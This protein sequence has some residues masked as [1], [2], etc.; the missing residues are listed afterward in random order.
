MPPNPSFRSSPTPTAPHQP[1]RLFI[2]IYCEEVAFEDQ[3][4]DYRCPQ[5]NA[6]KRR[7]SKFNVETGKVRNRGRAPACWLAAWLMTSAAGRAGAC[8]AGW[9]TAINGVGSRVGQQGGA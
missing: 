5:C 4:G 3:P 2:Q 6:P 1:P 7:F 8:C 9:L